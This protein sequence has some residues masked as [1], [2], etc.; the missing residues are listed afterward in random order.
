MSS[1]RPAGLYRTVLPLPGNEAQVPAQRLVL[2]H[3]TSDAGKP[4]VVLPNGLT[5]NRWLFGNKGFAVND[6]RWP[7]TLVALPAQG[8]YTLTGELTLSEQVKLPP[9]VLV[10]L[11]YTQ[12]GEGVLFPGYLQ[13][14]N[15]IQFEKTGARVSDLQ[16]DL[17][18]PI[19]FRLLVRP[20]NDP[21][22]PKPVT[23][24]G[25]VH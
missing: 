18:K 1:Q 4:A 12:Q 21:N 13:P 20:Q 17:F 3:P 24:G 23:D 6:E 14:G 25:A 5:D 8:F 19:D 16:L 9:G 22:A 10:Q 11:G 15:S 7:D 2:F